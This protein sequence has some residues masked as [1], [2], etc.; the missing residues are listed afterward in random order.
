MRLKRRG[1]TLIELLVVIAIIAILISLLLP[2]VQQA[3]EA[4]RRTQCKN[5]LKQVTLALHNYHDTHRCF[6][7]LWVHGRWF[8]HTWS[9]FLLDYVEQGNMSNIVNWDLPSWWLPG[10]SVPADPTNWNN[11]LLREHWWAHLKCPS[12]QAVGFSKWGGRD[13]LSHS[14]HN[15]VVCIGAAPLVDRGDTKQ[16]NSVFHGNSS[17]RIADISDGTSNTALVSEIVL[18]PGEVDMRGVSD[19]SEYSFYSHTYTPNSNL[20]DQ[21]ADRAASVWNNCDNSRPDAPCIGAILWPP[22]GCIV[23]AR[24]THPGGVQ[25]A[26]ADG[27]VHFASENIDL[28]TWQNLGA[29]QDGN[30][31]SGF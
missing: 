17:T 5:N 18:V 13:D 27:S 10:Y 6:P 8:Y 1:F 20:P 3:R 25:V 19:T 14:R 12:D 22:A 2:A 26:L 28:M 24:S 29:P 16:A 9:T 21:L 31:L 23:T 30:V 11:Q 7:P 4:A 15:F